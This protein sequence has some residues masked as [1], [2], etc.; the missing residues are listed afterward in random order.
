M[1]IAHA[2]RTIGILARISPV[3]GSDTRHE[4]ADETRRR[5]CH[6][7]ERGKVVEQIAIAA[8]GAHGQRIGLAH[9]EHDG[10]RQ[11]HITE[12]ASQIAVPAA[13]RD[14]GEEFL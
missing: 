4:V 12:F 14:A 1:T 11:V 10:L 9:V 5:R 13:H 6:A 2:V 7:R 8:G 3:C